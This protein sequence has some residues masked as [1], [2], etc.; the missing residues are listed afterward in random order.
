MSYT[1]TEW[2][3]KHILSYDY[4]RGACDMLDA[5]RVFWSDL[6]GEAM[7]QQEIIDTWGLTCGCGESLMR[8]FLNQTSW[9]IIA[10]FHDRIHGGNTNDDRA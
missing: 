5:V 3:D 6:V 4:L 8:S 10:D 2:S 7:S 1:E 9:D